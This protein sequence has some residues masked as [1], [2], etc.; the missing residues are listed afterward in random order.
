M[1]VHRTC[2]ATSTPSP[3]VNRGRRWYAASATAG[4]AGSSS[5][6]A[7][8]CT[9]IPS[10]RRPAAPDPRTAAATPAPAAPAHTAPATHRPTTARCTPPPCRPRLPPPRRGPSSAQ[11]PPT[12]LCPSRLLRA[13][14]GGYVEPGEAPR[15]ACIREVREELGIDPPIGPLLVVDWAPTASDGDKLLCVFAGGTLTP[16]QLAA[17][18]LPPDELRSYAFHTIT[19]AA[20]LTGPRLTRRLAAHHTAHP[21]YLEHGAPQAGA[22][23]GE[24]R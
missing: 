1:A 12:G 14:P 15:A 22:G 4:Y 21:T 6:G 20:P 2:A 19:D 3:A 7:S 24:V 11:P 17:I 5:H 13:P 18:H 16:D 9:P 8:P 23:T 10:V